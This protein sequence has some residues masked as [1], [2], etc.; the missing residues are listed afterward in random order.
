MKK[1]MIGLLTMSAFAM[2]AQDAKAVK[3]ALEAKDYTK[4]KEAAEAFYAK[5]AKKAEAQYY[6]HKAYFAIAN[7]VA[8]NAATPNALETGFE[9]LKQYL[10][11]DKKLEVMV[12]DGE[13]NTNEPA[14]RYYSAFLTRGDA[15]LKA[16]E[17]DSTQY[18]VSLYNFKKALAISKMFYDQGLIKVQ[19]DTSI[20]FYTGYAA[21]K[22]K[23]D[24]E[25][26]KHY[27]Q[28]TDLN[29]NITDDYR[30]PYQW[31][32][33][34]YLNVVN[35]K[36]Q[37]KAALD[38]GLKFYPKDEYLLQLKNNMI[39]GSGDYAEIL[40]NDEAKTSQPTAEFSDYI[41]YAEH[42]YDYVYALDKSTDQADRAAK[43]KKLEATVS[44]CLTLKPSNSEANYLAGLL[45]V[46]A[47]AGVEAK[48]K[49]LFGKNTP[50]DKVEREKLRAERLQ[51]GDVALKHFELVKS[52]LRSK[53]AKR[54]EVETDRMKD[55]L[56]KMIY[57]Y[58][59]KK[60]ETNKKS[61]EEDLKDLGG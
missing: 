19:V 51:I 20:V 50:A 2:Q 1:L 37:G 29:I 8:A 57:F 39:N 44:K 55:T 43:I 23:N 11:T 25:T 34:Y 33:N 3:K 35:K 22:A 47:Y 6:K 30:I 4:A 53:G 45:Q 9:A 52:I 54:T 16:G 13:Y 27:L 10:A 5:D 18:N 41:L 60:D 58:D 36:D 46:Q 26:E 48:I 56:K 28:L 17:G 32:A 7:D 40:A 31:I 42:L 21:M 15:A 14:N 61:A 38:A 59:A 49:A 24:A 12:K